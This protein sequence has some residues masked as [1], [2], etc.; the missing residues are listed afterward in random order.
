MS[1][2]ARVKDF[3]GNVSKEVI[4][5]VLLVVLIVLPIRFFVAQPFVVRGESMFPTFDNGDYLI[6]DEI[7]YRL[8]DP[9]RGEVVVFKYPNDPSV[10]YIKRVIG[11]PG[12]TVRISRGEV[13]V[14]K[15]DG[16]EIVIP[17]PYVVTEDATYTLERTLGT[18][19]YF[20]MGD[21]RPK[22]SDSRVWGPLPEENI[23]GRAFLR[24]LPFEDAEIFPGAIQQLQ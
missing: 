15:V 20:V 5:L 14:E 11:L 7:S 23:M 12:E 17:E 3:T 6:V 8:S 19:Q 24:L 4:L 2:F 16:S 13:T 1:F 21:N 22:S 9:K 18:G 10:F